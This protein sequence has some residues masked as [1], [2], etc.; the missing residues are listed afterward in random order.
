MSYPENYT[1]YIADKVGCLKESSHE[2]MECMRY[3]NE[4]DLRRGFPCTVRTKCCF[5]ISRVSS[6]CYN[7]LTIQ[8]LDSAWVSLVLVPVKNINFNVDFPV[9]ALCIAYYYV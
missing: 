5:E 9:V 1:R 7:Q 2:M 3:V 6:L 8:D 4:T